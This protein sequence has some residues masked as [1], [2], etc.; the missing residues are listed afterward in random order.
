PGAGAPWES[1][2]CWTGRSP[3][4]TRGTSDSARRYSP[5]R[6]SPPTIR[7]RPWVTIQLDSSLRVMRHSRPDAPRRG[8]ESLMQDSATA[9]DGITIR[10]DAGGAGSPA[11]VFVHG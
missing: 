2:G 3:A 11:I 1:G 5:N 6:T 7:A 8:G 9:P 10:F 4:T